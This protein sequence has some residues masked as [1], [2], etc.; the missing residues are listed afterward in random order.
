MASSEA[1]IC[2]LS[3]R[4][5]VISFLCAFIAV[6]AF[7]DRSNSQSQ[8]G[9][10]SESPSAPVQLKATKDDLTL[11]LPLSQ[12]IEKPIHANVRLVL[13]SPED[14]IRAQLSQELQLVRHQKQLVVRLAKPFEKVPAHEMEMLHWLRVRY[15]VTA[16]NGEILASGIEALHSATTDPF[17]L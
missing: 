13:L 1:L 3:S 9:R 6:L 5:F 8:R 12:S 2:H 15:E 16:L 17:V 7:G 10:L 11:A 4:R 14:I